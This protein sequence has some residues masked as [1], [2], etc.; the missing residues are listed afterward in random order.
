MSGF[1]SGSGSELKQIHSEIDVNGVH[2][3]IVCTGN[4]TFR[5][6]NML[7]FIFFRVFR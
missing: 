4:S 3:D 5:F 1:N 7:R 2:N 6:A